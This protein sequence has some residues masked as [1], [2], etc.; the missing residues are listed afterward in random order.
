VRYS[1]TVAEPA[2]RGRPRSFP[3]AKHM[4]FA[5][6]T[7]DFARFPPRIQNLNVPRILYPATLP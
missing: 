3:C 1:A 7:Q 6:F 5:A 4:N 2:Q